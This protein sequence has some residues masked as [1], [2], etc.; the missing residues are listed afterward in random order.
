MKVKLKQHRLGIVSLAMVPVSIVGIFSFILLF[1]AAPV[2]IVC[3]I[4]AARRGN[5]VMGI[6]GAAINAFLIVGL[7]T[8]WIVAATSKT[9]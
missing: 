3:G 6:T 1:V 5:K 8:L 2:G 9:D 7:L 4:I